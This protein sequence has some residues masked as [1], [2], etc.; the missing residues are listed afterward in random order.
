MTTYATTSKGYNSSFR[1]A[2][3]PSAFAEVLQSDFGQV[4][5]AAPGLTGGSGGSLATTTGRVGITWITTEGESAISTEATVSVTGA[6]G[7]IS[8][9]QPT[10]PTNGA[11]VLGWR[12][13]SSSGAAGSALLNVAANSTTQ[14]QSNIVTQQGTLLAFPVAT[15]TVV[16]LIYGTGQAEPGTDLSGIQQALQSVGANT[17]TDYYFRIPN[18]SSKWRMQF[19]PD[20]TR[21]QGL[22]DPTG[23]TAGPCDVVAPLYQGT[24]QSVSLGAYMVMGG[25]LYLATTAGTTAATFIGGPAFIQSKGSTTTDGTVVWTSYGKAVLIRL[26]FTNG[27]A[28]AQIPAAQEYDFFCA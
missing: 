8:V 22:P 6:T 14:V 5:G 18:S 24:A 12:V 4:G 2:L 21:P 26:R 10:V 28:T 23:I 27:S 13:Y 25:Y 9:A 3:P 16:V 1:G 7:S 17:S 20:Y 11:T 19:T 15:A